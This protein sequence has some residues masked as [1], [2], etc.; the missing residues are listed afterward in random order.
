MSSAPKK[1]QHKNNNYCK[2][3]MFILSLISIGG[4]YTLYRKLKKQKDNQKKDVRNLLSE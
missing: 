1:E 2:I 3:G 4:T